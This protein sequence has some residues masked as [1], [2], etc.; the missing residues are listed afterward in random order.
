MRRPFRRG[1]R[2][3]AATTPSA[4]RG[5]IFESLGLSPSKVAGLSRSER[6][7]KATTGA[8]G[9]CAKGGAHVRRRGEPGH[10]PPAPGS[11]DPRRCPA[12]VRACCDSREAWTRS[13]A[14]R[15]RSRP[16][17]ARGLCRLRSAGEFRAEGR[18]G[19][20]A[21]RVD[22]RRPAHAGRGAQRRRHASRTRLTVWTSWQAVKA[23]FE[24]GGAGTSI[25]LE[26]SC[27]KATGS[28]ALSAVPGSC[29][30]QPVP[31]GVAATCRNA[32]LLRNPLW[33]ST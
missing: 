21:P 15:K 4:A 8:R 11:A 10:S 9:H 13:V 33:V 24:R 23:S 14:A 30:A 31:Q 17:S 32:E 22:A 19:R 18:W 6:E 2:A 3:A 25:H 1:S 27:R 29:N 12:I 26:L 5:I 20:H 16:C 28:Y 7:A